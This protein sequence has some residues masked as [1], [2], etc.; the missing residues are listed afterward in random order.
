AAEWHREGAV[1]ELRVVDA[2]EERP[3]RRRR[4]SSHGEEVGDRQLEARHAVEVDADAQPRPAL[5]RDVELEVAQLA[6]PDVRPDRRGLAVLE[7]ER[8]LLAV[9]RWV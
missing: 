9:R 2:D 4:R 5:P 3:R 8:P 1:Q 6:G 7:R